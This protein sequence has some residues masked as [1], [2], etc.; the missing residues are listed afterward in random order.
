MLPALKNSILLLI[1]AATIVLWHVGTYRAYKESRIIQARIERLAQA[2]VLH[3]TES[4]FAEISAGASLWRIGGEEWWT[5][6]VSVSARRMKETIFSD[7]TRSDIESLEAIAGHAESISEVF[8]K[9]RRGHTLPRLHYE[10]GGL[11][12]V[13]WVA[14]GAS[15]YALLAEEQYTACLETNPRRPQCL[16][17]LFDV[18]IKGRAWGNAR[19]TGEEILRYWPA[20]REVRAV[21]EILQKTSPEK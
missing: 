8:F 17:G 4:V 6:L 12:Q 1:I 21:L 16:L 15:K 5:N 19:L 20:N 9:N 7:I 13:I 10:L 18:Y 11:Y 2:Y 3:D 14:T